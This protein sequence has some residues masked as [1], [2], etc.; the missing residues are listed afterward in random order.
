MKKPTIDE[1]VLRTSLRL[2]DIYDKQDKL[3]EEMRKA[4]ETRRVAVQEFIRANYMGD[5]HAFDLL[6]E[7]FKEN[8]GGVGR[9]VYDNSAY[10]HVQTRMLVKKV[11]EEYPPV[12]DQSTTTEVQP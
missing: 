4:N 3:I 12:V 11:R 8:K 9:R 5:Q 7:A 10:D 1:R 6:K 2:L